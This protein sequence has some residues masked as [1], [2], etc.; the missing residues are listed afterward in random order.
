MNRRTAKKTARKV[1]GDI[2]QNGGTQI[3]T[4]IQ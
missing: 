2:Q 4:K 1:M 3:K